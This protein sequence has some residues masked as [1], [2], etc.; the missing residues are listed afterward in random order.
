MLKVDLTLEVTEV[1][2]WQAIIP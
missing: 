1:H 2:H